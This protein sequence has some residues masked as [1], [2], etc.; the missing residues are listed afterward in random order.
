MKNYITEQEFKNQDFT[1][2][3]LEIGE[4]DNCT[5]LNCLFTESNLSEFIFS[6]CVFEACDMSNSKLVNTSFREVNFVKCKLLGLH[7]DDCNPFLI[8]FSFNSCY[9]NFAS[10]YNL[11]LKKTIF[12]NCKLEEVDFSEADISLGSF[13]ECELFNATFDRTGLEGADFRTARNFAIDP[14]KNRIKKAKFS[15]D[16]LS[17]LLGKYQLKI[18]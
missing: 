18:D 7:F 11:K 10:F 5:F 14:E 15:R 9:L 3:P 4:Y 2:T 1:K 8:A 16:S 13:R 17:G 12:N 6:E